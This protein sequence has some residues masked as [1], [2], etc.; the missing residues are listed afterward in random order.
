M[1]KQ[2]T[3]GIW[4]RISGD[5]TVA[6]AVGAPV[7]VR[8][9]WAEPAREVSVAA[10]PDPT[11]ALH[12]LAASYQDSGNN[13]QAEP[14]YRRVLAMTE[15][16]LGPDHPIVAGSLHNLAALYQARGE[17]ARAEP[18]CRRALSIREDALGPDHPA[19]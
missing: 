10:D 18:L 8:G 13:A 12:N 14:L 3:S 19:V 2:R 11:S 4:T 16:A 9:R 7:G 5:R 1:T 17:L 15:S 6:M